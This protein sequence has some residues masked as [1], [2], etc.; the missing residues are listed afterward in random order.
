MVSRS[1]FT[2]L[3]HSAILLALTVLGMVLV[4]VVPAYDTIFGHGWSFCAGLAAYA[5]AAISFL[6]TASRYRVSRFWALA[7]PLIALFYLAATFSSALDHWR[8]TGALWKNRSYGA[9]A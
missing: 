9:D 6:P 1:A 4:F 5:L 2:Q 7:L 8:G 3:N